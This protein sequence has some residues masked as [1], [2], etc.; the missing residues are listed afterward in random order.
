MALTGILVESDLKAFPRAGRGGDNRIDR[1]KGVRIRRVGHHTHLQVGIG[2]GGTPHKGSL[3]RVEG[4]ALVEQRGDRD[5]VGAGSAGVEVEG[6]H[7][8]IVRGGD[9]GII[10]GGAVGVNSV[11]AGRI[12]ARA[13]AVGVEAFHVGQ[14]VEGRARD[15]NGELS[16]V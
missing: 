12:D 8:V 9:V 13:C 4:N 6:T 14:G 5:V 3:Q 10:G 15:E 2:I 11:P 7:T 16:G 1:H